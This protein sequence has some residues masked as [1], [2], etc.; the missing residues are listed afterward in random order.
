MGYLERVVNRQVLSSQTVASFDINAESIVGG[1]Y[2]RLLANPFLLSP[3]ALRRFYIM[4][5]AAGMEDVLDFSNCDFDARSKEMK[6][7]RGMECVAVTAGDDRRMKL[8]EGVRG[9][10]W[11]NES[12]Q[13]RYLLKWIYLNRVI[14]D[15]I[16]DMTDAMA[17]E[18]YRRICQYS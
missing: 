6:R 4:Q 7:I 15:Y 13:D 11:D 3:E 8:V 17:K 1:L 18:E 5:V 14:A 12:I 16:G 2:D 10:T 9:A